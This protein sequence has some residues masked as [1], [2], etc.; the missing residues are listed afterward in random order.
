MLALVLSVISYY[1]GA[2]MVLAVSGA[3]PIQHGDDPE[4]FNVVEEMAIAAG[5][6]TPAVYLIHDPAPN[7]FATGRDP[8]HAAIA[9]TTGLRQ[10]MTRDELQ[11]VV[12]HEMSHVRNYDIRLMLLLAVLV[13]MVVMMCDLFW[14]MLR[15]SSGGSRSPAERRQGRRR[16]ALS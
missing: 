1:A 3:R 9:V 10:M 2:S 4:L 8:K 14:Q 6:P 11:G 5:V 16:R 15:F 13:G 12:A 7:A